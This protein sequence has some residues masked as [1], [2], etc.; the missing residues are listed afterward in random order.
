MCYNNK[1]KPDI[2][3]VKSVRIRS[4]SDTLFATFILN[5]ERYSVSLRIQSECGKIRI[6]ITANTDNFYAVIIPLDGT[7]L[8]AVRGLIHQEVPTRVRQRGELKRA[9]Q[10]KPSGQQIFSTMSRPESTLIKQD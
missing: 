5:T 7:H 3:C 1:T 10:L 8:V 4:Y 6:R 9:S 2:Y